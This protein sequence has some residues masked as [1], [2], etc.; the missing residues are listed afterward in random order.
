MTG[1]TVQF[2]TGINYFENLKTR[3]G[4]NFALTWGIHPE[5]VAAEKVEVG[6]AI[7]MQK[8]L[9]EKQLDDGKQILFITPA[10]QSFS[11]TI[12]SYN[13]RE[14]GMDSFENFEKQVEALFLLL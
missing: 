14:T 5:D 3:K 12:T 2:V 9:I 1:E 7:I 10:V 13:A 11:T 8:E 4:E 6:A